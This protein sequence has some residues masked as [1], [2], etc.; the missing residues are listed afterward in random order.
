MSSWWC[1]P[2]Q[3]GDI[4]VMCP[5]F[6]WSFFQRKRFSNNHLSSKKKMHPPFI[7]NPE[8]WK[9]KSEIFSV[10]CPTRSHDALLPDGIAPFSFRLDVF[11]LVSWQWM[12]WLCNFTACSMEVTELLENLLLFWW[13]PFYPEQ[14]GD[15]VQL[16]A[17]QFLYLIEE[18]VAGDGEEQ[19]CSIGSS[20]KLP[21]HSRI[22][23]WGSFSST[24]CFSACS[25]RTM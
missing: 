23:T 18:S 17:P 19:L 5:K 4:L 2:Y 11:P 3:L 8:K 9:R 13:V 25:S 10:L 24:S 1:R 21:C 6:F 7:L 20:L 22:C 12:W 15:M 16:G 14:K